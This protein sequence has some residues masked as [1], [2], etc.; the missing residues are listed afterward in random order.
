V[1]RIVAAWARQPH[2]PRPRRG[3]EPTAP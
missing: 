3:R 2:H 1:N